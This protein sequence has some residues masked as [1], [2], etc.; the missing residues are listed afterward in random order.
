MRFRY[1][2]RQFYNTTDFDVDPNPL[3]STN[4]LISPNITDSIS[5]RLSDAMGK[6]F[7][8]CINRMTM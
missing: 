8:N 1:I 3:G 2:N 6:T 5:I 4:T 7:L